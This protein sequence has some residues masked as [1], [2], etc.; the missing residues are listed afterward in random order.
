MHAR[1]QKSRS[2]LMLAGWAKWRRG[3]FL[4]EPTHED[5]GW[6]GLGLRGRCHPPL[7]WACNTYLCNLCR[8][9]NWEG[10]QGGAGEEGGSWGQQG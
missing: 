10:G 7:H 1:T 8:V 9:C 3:R 6:E 2:H 4:H 5:Q